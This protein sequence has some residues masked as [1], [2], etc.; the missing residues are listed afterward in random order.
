MP[1]S[2][3]VANG[4]RRRASAAAVGIGGDED[5]LFAFA[6]SMERAGE[7]RDLFLR[8]RKILYPQLGIARKPDPHGGVRGPFG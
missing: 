1:R 7:C 8:R 5:D 3:T 2:I 4:A 6:V